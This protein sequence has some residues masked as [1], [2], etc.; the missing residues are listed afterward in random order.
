MNGDIR[1]ELVERLIEHCSLPCV[2]GD[3]DP[4]ATAVVDRYV[5]LGLPTITAHLFGLY[6]AV[7]SMITPPGR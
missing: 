6:F 2:T 5:E 7:I 1:T 3:E 4:I